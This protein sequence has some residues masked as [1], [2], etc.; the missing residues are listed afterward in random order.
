MRHLNRKQKNSLR[1]YVKARWFDQGHIK[2]M[3][4]NCTQDLTDDM[5]WAVF[6]IMPFECFDSHVDRFVDDIKTLSDCKII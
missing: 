5:Y 6:N 3:F 4:F 1:K 2:P